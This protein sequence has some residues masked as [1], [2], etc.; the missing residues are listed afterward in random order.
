MYDQRLDICGKVEPLYVFFY[1]MDESCWPPD[2]KRSAV[3]VSLLSSE[4]EMTRSLRSNTFSAFFGRN[5]SMAI[6]KLNRSKPIK[7]TIS[8]T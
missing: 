3:Y 7:I 5:T 8:K 6:T 1:L 4:G 2:E